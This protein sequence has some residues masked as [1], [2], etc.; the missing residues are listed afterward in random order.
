MPA[1]HR[2]GH[3]AGPCGHH[4]LRGDHRSGHDLQRLQGRRQVKRWRSSAAAALVLQRSTQPRLPVP[5]M[6]IAAIPLEEKR[7]LAQVLGATAHVD[8]MADDAA[9]ADY[10]DH[11]GGVHHA[12][13]A[14]GR[15]ASADLAVDPA[16]GGTATILG[17]MPLDCKVGLSAMDLL[18]GQEIAR[19]DHGREPLPGRSAPSGRLLH[20]R[21]T[22]SRH[23]SSPS[24]S[25]WKRSTK[26][27]KRC[28]QG[29][30]PAA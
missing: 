18:V 29:P 13:E 12:I 1:S 23:A 25:R 14:V 17:M 19:C 16:R 30:A 26:G 11:R 8:A 3:A 4:R 21:P 28:K 24:V 7:E 9:E 22:R 10:R 27:S 15:Q 20:A 2:Q 5:G 6:V